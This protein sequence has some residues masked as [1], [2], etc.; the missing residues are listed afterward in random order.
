MSDTVQTINQEK[1]WYKQFWPWALIFLPGSVVVAS[2]VTIFLAVQGADSLVVDD[3]YKEAMLINRNFSRVEYARKIELTGNLLIKNNVFQ[4]NI[5][6]LKD[7]IKLA[8]AL[9]LKFIHPADAVKDF[10][11]NLVQVDDTFL[12]PPAKRNNAKVSGN[13]I[14]QKSEKIK[15]LSQAAWYVSLQPLDKNWQLKGRIKNSNENISLY[16]E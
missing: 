3:Y 14:S 1:E 16:A 2:A 12:K 15:L 13:Y 4:L 9:I 8:P 6:V 10:S 5:S 7:K 11:I